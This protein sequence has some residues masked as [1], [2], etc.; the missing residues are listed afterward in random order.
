MSKDIPL[1]LDVDGTLIK[2]DLTQEL[3][4]RGVR[5]YPLKIFTFLFLVLT[6]RSKLKALLVSLVG[7][8][9]YPKSLP[10]NDAIIEK[11]KAAKSEGRRVFLCSGSQE[12][13]VGQLAD[14]F[15]WIDGTFATDE[16]VN[17]T[18]K[19]KA[20]F[21]ETRFPDGFD[22]IGNSTQ[23]F[24]VW[25]KARKAYAIDPPSGTAKILSASGRPVEILRKRR[26][27]SPGLFKSL[28]LHQWAKN[29]LIFFVPILVMERLGTDDIPGLLAGFI[30]LGLLASGIYI[31]NDLVDIDSDRQ[32][33]T[34]RLKPFVG[35]NLSVPAGIFTMI[36]CIMGACF[37][38]L[39]LPLPFRIVLLVYFCITVLYSVFVKRRTIVDVLAL[40][41]L[42]LVRVIAGAAIVEEPLAV[43]FQ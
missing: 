1:I 31:F 10:Y 23:D 38:A 28:R 27:P 24:P 30:A 33:A 18:R 32:H 7:E 5:L 26:F 34:K 42:F 36:A 16:N 17:L 40:V 3:F 19:N 25:R 35:G 8:E 12:K 43:L 14:G 4:L 37:L 21:L 2:N 15:R 41:T 20:D 9:I 11:G 29:I 6:S 22:Y 39:L 13:L